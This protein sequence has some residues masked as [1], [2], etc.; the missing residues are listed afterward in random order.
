VRTPTLSYVGAADIECPA[1]QT[2]EFGHALR[3]LNVPEETIIYPNEGHAIR[4]PAHL[5]DMDE[6]TLAWFDRYLKAGA[7]QTP[8]SLR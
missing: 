3:A 2:Q 1:A 6:R 4:D 8:Q 7:A 5:A